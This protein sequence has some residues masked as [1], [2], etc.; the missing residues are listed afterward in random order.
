MKRKVKGIGLISGG[1]DS[2]LAVKVLQEQDLDLLGLT[3][4][5]PFFGAEPGVSA[6]RITGIPVRVVDIG[7]QHL[8]MLKNPRYGYGSQMNPCI[9]CHALMLQEAGR[10]MESEGAAFLFTGEVLGQRPMSQRRDS[11]RSVEN[12]SG[13]PG[14]VLRP[15]SAKLLPPTIPE[16][17]GLVDRDRLLAIQGRGRKPQRALAAHYC[18]TEYPESGGGCMLTKEGY[19]DRLRAL[20]QQNPQASVHEVEFLKWG[21]NFR[22]PGGSWCII[23]R[24]QAG[25]ERLEALAAEE[26]LI[27]RAPD[28]KGATGLL[29]G[30][31]FSEDDLPLAAS[32]IVAYSDT[33]SDAPVKV[34]WRGRERAGE[35]AA[36][37]V[38]KNQFTQYLV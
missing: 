36:Y 38:E 8:R 33:P 26:D 14:R 19:A 22:L 30:S 37:K 1:L 4:I 12:L 9:D 20:L 10:L 5:T 21:R 32:L 24:N 18:I 15:L 34:V 23:G 2:M 11:L 16:M 25:N 7:E 29:M 35:L 27:L 3:F 31:S 28:Y 6:G 13:H 17:E